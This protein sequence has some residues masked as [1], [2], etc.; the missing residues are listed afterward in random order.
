MNI[1]ELKYKI[2]EIKKALHGFYSSQDTEEVR[3]INLENE[4]KKIFKKEQKH[5]K[6]KKSGKI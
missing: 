3:T 1:L 5:T 6:K 4:P 2:Y